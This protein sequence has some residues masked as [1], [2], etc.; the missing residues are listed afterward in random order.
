MSILLLCRRWWFAERIKEGWDGRMIQGRFF[1][2]SWDGLICVGR[3]DNNGRNGT[4]VNV[5][6]VDRWQWCNDNQHEQCWKGS[7]EVRQWG[8]VFFIFLSLSF[9]QTFAWPSRKSSWLMWKR[10][11]EREEERS[12]RKWDVNSCNAMHFGQDSVLTRYILVAGKKEKL[13][14]SL[15]GFIWLSPFLQPIPL[16][17]SSR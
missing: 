9:F 7:K 8:M 13:S 11:K 14:Y 16:S 12:E 4:V 17:L 3:S 1:V 15:F 5:E 10:G 2:V 6:T